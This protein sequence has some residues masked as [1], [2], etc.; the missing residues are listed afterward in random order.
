MMDLKT[1]LYSTKLK[2]FN[3]SDDLSHIIMDGSCFYVG[4]LDKN[5]VKEIS[6]PKNTERRCAFSRD[7]SFAVVQSDRQCFTLTDGFSEKQAFKR[8]KK[9]QYFCDRKPLIYKDTVF[10]F[11]RLMG[12]YSVRDELDTTTLYEINGKDEKEL[13]K[14]RKSMLFHAKI[15]NDILY[16]VFGAS[17]PQLQDA[18]LTIYKRNLISGEAEEL[19]CP[20]EDFVALM[21]AAIIPEKQLLAVVKTYMPIT[22]KA[23]R[24][25]FYK[26]DTFEL[27]CERELPNSN[28]L[29]V[30]ITQ[31]LCGGKYVIFFDLFGFTIYNTEDFSLEK[32]VSFPGIANITV[33]DND[34][35]C[36]INAMYDLVVFTPT[37]S[38][39]NDELINKIENCIKANGLSRLIAH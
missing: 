8:N 3:I 33:C 22:K 30:P 26:T 2:Y 28:F 20:I 29:L 34:N 23:P 16:A 5:D 6:I 4:D 13:W 10:C 36:C 14:I 24:L 39:V 37:Q 35:Y 7:N 25:S 19:Y 31:T 12:E 11:R 21:S 15:E 18:K 27:V 1:I 9:S 38:A 32:E 17:P